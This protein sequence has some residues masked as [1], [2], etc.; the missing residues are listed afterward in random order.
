MTTIAFIGDVM[1]GRGVNELIGCRAP[2]AFWGDVLPVL[3]GAD[4]V[5]ANLECAI[6]DRTD[7]WGRTPK[8]FHFR[9]GPA[10]VAVLRAANVSGVSLA[11]NHTLDYREPGLLDT[12]AHLE[13]AGIPC[14]GAGRNLD[15]ARAVP[16]IDAG[17]VRLG[18]AAFT[19]NEPPFAAGA[20]R[21]GTSHLE[22]HTG[23]HGLAQLERAVAAARAAAADLVVL[24]LHWGPNM[25]TSP[26]PRHRD[27][28]RT[29]VECGVDLV[30]GHS[31]HVF[32]GVEVYRERP[33]L[34]DTGDFL[35]DYAVDGALRND[36]SFVFLL[37]LDGGRLRRLRLRPVRLTYGAVN[38]ARGDEFE[39]IRARMREH[40]A[41]F[42]TRLEDTEEGLEIAL[43]LGSELE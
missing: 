2:E 16:V 39:A 32:Q 35:D 13:A 30:Y 4:A 37:D 21:P 15:A 22:I 26:P 29:A 8:V 17:G 38:L 9:A 34:Y 42:D 5:V 20:D 28:A 23:P 18:L 10:A 31:A 7:P 25:V 3:R 43:D 19:D 41:E 33:I 36:W 11:N 40:C 27:F 24:S 12:L 14:A 6:T 1:L